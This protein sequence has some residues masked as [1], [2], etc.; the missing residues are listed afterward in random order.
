MTKR[1]NRSSRRPPFRTAAEELKGQDAIRAIEGR[2]D[3]LLGRLG[4][5]LWPKI[6]T[7]DTDANGSLHSRSQIRVKV[8]GRDLASNT[9]SDD[10]EIRFPDTA[11]GAEAGARCP[12]FELHEEPDHVAILA[13]LPGADKSTIKITK[14]TT[15]LHVHADGSRTF[16]G[17]VMLP[18]NACRLREW[19]FVNGILTIILDRKDLAK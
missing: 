6:H 12:E 15:A 14:T 10:F 3:A 18:A 9:T 1:D 2:L 7:N 11:G 19:T 16:D 4:E 5:A 8:T 17:A 13:E